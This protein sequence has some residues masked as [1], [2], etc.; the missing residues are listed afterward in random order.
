MTSSI[1]K[2]ALSV[3]LFVAAF[4]APALAHAKPQEVFNCASIFVSENSRPPINA[5]IQ[6]YET[7]RLSS[8]PKKATKSYARTHGWKVLER[9]AQ[10][11]AKKSELTVLVDNPSSSLFLIGDFNEWGLSPR[12]QDRF[13]AVAE[14]P[15]LFQIVIDHASTGLVNGTSYRLLLNGKSVL[16][17]AALMFTTEDYAKRENRLNLEG[18][19]LNS[20][21]WDHGDPANY[22]TKTGFVDVNGKPG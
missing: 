9:D 2:T 14:H 15:E 16:D 18:N 3:F 7:S 11:R 8:L 1:R 21:Y 6:I 22:K 5:D 19:Y 10:G 20:V 13:H 12:D 17:P 4:V